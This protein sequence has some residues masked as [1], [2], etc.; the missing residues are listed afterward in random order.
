M[1]ADGEG[2]APL[3]TGHGRWPWI[4]SWLYVSVGSVAMS[5]AT[6]FEVAFGGSI[7]AAN[8]NTVGVLPMDFETGFVF[9]D[10]LA[11]R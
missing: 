4:S 6:R 9:A 3:D 11:T 2:G 7:S 8:L 5:T 1:N 10:G